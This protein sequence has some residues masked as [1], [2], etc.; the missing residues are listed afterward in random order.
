[1]VARTCVRVARLRRLIRRPAHP[2]RLATLLGCFAALAASAPAQA[3]EL[4]S[5]GAVARDCG[6][7]LLAPSAS[8]AD[9][10]AWTASASGFLTATLDG[11]RAGDW[12]LALFDAAGDPLGGSTAFGSDER[13][14]LWVEPGDE[15]VVQGCRRSGASPASVPLRLSLQRMASPPASEPVSLVSVPIAGPQDVLRFERLG[16]DVTHDVSA[17]EA[18]LAL[19]SQDERRLLQSRGFGVRTIEDDLA[20]VDSVDRTAEARAARVGVASALP[21]GREQYR[22]Y[23]DYTTEMKDLAETNP[24]LVR[25][26]VIGQTLE[27]RPIQGIE[28]AADVEADDGRPAFLNM[29]VHHAREWPSG[30]LPM[31]FALDLVDGYGT[32]ER[33]TALL[34]EVRVFIFPVI[35]VDGFIASRSYGTSPLDDDP[36]ATLPLIINDQAAYKR[37]NCRPTVPGSEEL[38]CA[39]RSNSGVDLNRNYGA[40]WGGPGSGSDVTSQGYRGPAPYSEPESQ[41]VREFTSSVHPT[42]FITNHTFTED[43]KWLRQ[44]GFDADFLPSD[45]IGAVSPDEAAMKN[46]G[47]DMAAATGWTSE[48]GYETLG[49]ITGATEDWNYFAQGTLGYTPEVRGLNFHANYADS[50]VEEYLGDSEHE[51]LGVREAYLLAAERAGDESNHAVLEGSAPE[52]ATLTLRKA[53]QT[54]TSQ[55]GLAVDDVLVTTLEVGPSGTYEWHVMPSSRPLVDGESWT[56]SCTLP[57]EDAVATTV[58]VDRGDVRTVDFDSACAPAVGPDPDPDPVLT[59][60][61]RVAT[62]VGTEFND[63]DGAALTGTAG[64]DVIVAL[65]G[66]DEIR[67]GAGNDVVCAGEGE[68]DARGG[69]GADA[70][71]GDAGDDD[72]FGGA[73]RDVLRGNTGTDVLNGGPGRDRCGFERGE[74]RPGCP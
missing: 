67:S 70:I 18:T 44:P 51:G 72:I 58:A 33:I 56:M 64:R 15:L 5:P 48:R 19:Y 17:T 74:R 31:E 69:T 8:G 71:R 25:E 57:G 24:E 9:R 40:Y 59:C 35:N 13:V 50:V 55:E 62:I 34:D 29:G 46:L 1:V 54:P 27:G 20:A 11:G 14:D 21:S 36:N 61:G 42:V 65:E 6:A 60:R 12:D 37:K 7:A 10:R 22:V 41:A 47:D 63:I 4:A 49:D 66:D 52:G 73:G 68:D 26:V 38:P 39:S 3:A 28:I 45:E 30:E 23:E 2:S 53:F 43:G 16:L 32:D